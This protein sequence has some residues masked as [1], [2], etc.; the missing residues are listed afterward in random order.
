M[1]DRKSRTLFS[2][3]PAPAV[4]VCPSVTSFS[5]SVRASCASA[6]ADVLPSCLACRPGGP[7]SR[8]ASDICQDFHPHECATG[9]CIL[10]GTLPVT[11]TGQ[12]LHTSGRRDGITPDHG[13][14]NVQPHRGSGDRP[15]LSLL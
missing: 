3:S 5:L 15:V 11:F 8:T 14:K 4:S 9:F 7:N 12:F 2:S 6:G 10:S 13:S 1:R